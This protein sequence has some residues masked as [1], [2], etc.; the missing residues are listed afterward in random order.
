MRTRTSTLL[1]LLASCAGGPRLPREPTGARVLE[2]T[3]RIRGGRHAVGAG[4][5]AAW[6]RRALRGAD[7]RGGRP[8]SWEGADLS[9]LLEGVERERGVDTVL[10]RTRGGVAAP[11]PLWIVWQFRP[12]LADRSGG[13]PLPGL[14][15]A[16]PNV[17][18]SGLAGDPRALAWWAD[19]VV[20][21][22]LVE[23][24][25]HARALA[26]PAGAAGAARLGA[27]PF[28]ARCLAC[29]AARGVGG[30][31]GPALTFVAERLGPEPF[32][33]AIRRHAAWPASRPD[34]APSAEDTG[35]IHAYLDALGRAERAG[36]PVEPADEGAG[37]GSRGERP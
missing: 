36:L 4:D 35:R 11:V 30:A 27:G 15:L 26:P 25:V 33:L 31:A 28:Q 22:E 1:L 17:E 18:Q 10:V 8:A 7:P 2:V 13:T 5:L 16:W 9:A 3:G 34:L 12:V 14:V 6:P 24:P 32:F 29:H 19:D 21:L 37:P 23:W 20:A